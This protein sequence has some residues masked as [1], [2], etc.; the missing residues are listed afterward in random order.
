[1]LGPVQR[2]GQMGAVA[3]DA[4]DPPAAH[5]ARPMLDKNAH[6]VGVGCFYNTAKV[7]ACRGLIGEGGRRAGAIRDI[8]AAARVRI[9]THPGHRL[10]SAAVDRAP[11]AFPA[12]QHR[13]M[14]NNLAL[15]LHAA[16]AADLRHDPAAGVCLSRHD[17][18][19]GGIDHGEIGIALTLQRFLHF[20]HG[21]QHA[22]ALP[23]DGSRIA[24]APG[25]RGR[26]VFARNFAGVHAGAVDLRKHGV[27]VLPG[28]GGKETVRLTG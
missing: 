20:G 6:A 27:H 19:G 28:A 25:T 3:Q 23:F 12:A 7:H 5:A 8:G 16:A 21:R 18:V 9:E 15:V 4:A 10:R 24:V 14:R 2:N 1:M 26:A 22:P 17:A 11:L 13:V